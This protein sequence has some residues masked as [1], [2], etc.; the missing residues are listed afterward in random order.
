MSDENRSRRNF[1]RTAGSSA[2]AVVVFSPMLG[3]KIMAAA[4]SAGA[5]MNPI[6]LDV[7]KPEYA[8]LSKVGGALKVPNP[9]DAKRPI[10]VSRTSETSVAAFS[11]RCTHFGC[12]VPVPVNN[13]IECPCHGSLFDANGKV[14]KGPARKDLL[15]YSAVLEGSIITINE[16]A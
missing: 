11:S 14:T 15:A 4:R 3:T 1:I 6:V 8:A 9:Q 16:K 12:E 2:F 10:I 5:P 7:A 13:V